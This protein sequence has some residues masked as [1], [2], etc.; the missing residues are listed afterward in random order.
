MIRLARGAP[1][2]LAAALA[3]L[4]LAA[5]GSSGHAGP[6][7]GARTGAAPAPAGCAAGGEDVPRTGVQ[8]REGARTLGVV[9]LRRSQACGTAWG[10]VLGLPPDARLELATLRRPGGPELRLRASGPYARSG[11]SGKELLDRHG[12]VL[13]RAKVMRAGAVVAEAETPCG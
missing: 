1:P 7:P 13:A 2:P 3:A 9:L 5:C 10:V 11:V 4:S 12:C 8:L 6:A